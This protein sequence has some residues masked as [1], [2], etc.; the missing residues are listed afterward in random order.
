MAGYVAHLR[1]E[2]I[3][4]DMCD[5]LAGNYRRRRAHSS[6]AIARVYYQLQASAIDR[7]VARHSPRFASIIAV[8]SKDRE[9]IAAVAH[10]QV[11]S[12]P[13]GV[14]TAQFRPM[15]VPIQGENHKILFVGAMRSWANR[16]AVDWF[17]QTILPQ[18]RASVTAATLEIVGS[19]ADQ[20]GLQVEGVN[21]RGFCSDLPAAYTSCRIFVCPLRTG[22]GI[23]NKVLEAM[24]SG[25]AIVTTSIGAEGLG[26]VH[27]KH[28]L[29]ADSPEEFARTVAQLLSN[30]SLRAR[31]GN[32]AREFALRELSLDAVRAAL[33]QVL[34]ARSTRG[35]SLRGVLGSPELDG[36][37]IVRGRRM[38]SNNRRSAAMICKDDLTL[39]S[40]PLSCD[41]TR[42]RVTVSGIPFELFTV[43]HLLDLITEPAPQSRGRII[44]YANV[45]TVNLASRVS[46][47]RDFLTKETSAN[48]CDGF[49]LLLGAR[50]LGYR[51][52]P[53]HRMTAPDFFSDLMRLSARKKLSVY[54][55][56]GKPGVVDM[57]MARAKETAPTLEISGHHGYFP[58]QGAENDMILEEIRRRE[59]D[60]LCLGFGSPLQEQWILENRTYLNV[61]TYLL[62]GACLDFY[63]GATWRGPRWLTDH[64]AEWVCR[65]ITEPARLWRRYLVGNPQFLGRVLLEALSRY[66]RQ[67]ILTLD[68]EEVLEGRRMH[69]PE[70]VS[71]RHR[72]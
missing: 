15:P 58:K 52:R 33:D 8:S 23:K 19:G 9:G 2:H 7:F 36:F 46:W 66:G 32:E 69:R 47:F 24:A 5:D 72:S 26:V 59:P 40:V 38:E 14:D 48:F 18:I 37:E 3:L 4:L 44:T 67:P 21:V 63:T 45:H 13:L 28:L 20:L 39:H 56:A 60:L 25:C 43:A 57:A 31:L 51:T 35:S 22:T 30:E 53:E 71:Y 62:L 55:L 12:I 70:A 64:G 11:H 54:L 61:G 50:L 29:I 27:G 6:N 42:E 16:D 65:L 49:G 41:A 68:E 10:T 17:V 1:G 34:N